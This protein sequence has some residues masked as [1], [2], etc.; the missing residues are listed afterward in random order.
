MIQ[1]VCRCGGV[2][3]GGRGVLL[4][5]LLGRAATAAADRAADGRCGGG[6]A[7]AAVG[8]GTVAEDDPL[9]ELNH[10]VHVYFVVKQRVSEM[11]KK[12]FGRNF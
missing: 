7:V 9:I 3:G 8:V 2:D 6:G 11:S 12:Q 10:A 4:V 5:L 1:K